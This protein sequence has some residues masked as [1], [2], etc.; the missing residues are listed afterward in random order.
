MAPTPV[1][2]AGGVGTGEQIAAALALGCAGVWSG[3]LWL[4]VE[5]ADLPP[6]QKQSLLDADEP[7]HR[8]VAVVHRQAVPHAA[9]RVDRGLGAT[10]TPP[11]RCRMPL[12]YMVSGECV[13]RGTRYAEKSQTVAFNPCGQVV[14]QLGTERKTRDVM[15]ELVEGYLD[16]VERLN[17]LNG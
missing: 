6:A 17:K 5:E 14:G 11:I 10:P 13:V 16:A 15:Q 7:R 4:T 2:A 3:T 8:A 12:Q 1:L 9:Q